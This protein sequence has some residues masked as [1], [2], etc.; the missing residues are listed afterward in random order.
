VDKRLGRRPD[1]DIDTK[2]TGRASIELVNS[3]DGVPVATLELDDDGEAVGLRVVDAR[4]PGGGFER[5]RLGDVE[6]VRCDLSGCDFSEAVWLRVKLVDCR[7]SAI[8]LP[9]ANLREV[10]FVD[11][12]LDDANFRLAQMQRV[13][14]DASV[15]GG[16]EFVGARLADVSFDGSDLAGAD[17]SNAKCGAVD[18]RG[19]RLDG[20]RGV[21][22]LGGA[23]IGADQL[24]GLAPALAQALGLRVLADGQDAHD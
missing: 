17:F 1:H 2:D 13:R 16:A 23:T 3:S 21:A 15:L 6:L 9:Q 18:L 19:A 14:F 22:S 8:E 11:C 20:L 24:V 5:A 4:H 7:A 12:K 10:T